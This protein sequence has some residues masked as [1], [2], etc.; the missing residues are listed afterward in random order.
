[1]LFVENKHFFY[2]PVHTYDGKVLFANDFSSY[3]PIIQ[4]SKL[5]AQVY[6]VRCS[7]MHG[8]AIVLLCNSNTVTDYEYEINDYY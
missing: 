2:S 7:H 1:M 5:W 6:N 8:T 3:S 4:H